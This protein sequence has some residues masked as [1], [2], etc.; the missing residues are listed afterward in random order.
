MKTCLTTSTSSVAHLRLANVA[1]AALLEGRRRR[2]SL[3]V[4]DD[5]RFE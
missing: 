2:R 1:L 5:S 4:Q 3:V